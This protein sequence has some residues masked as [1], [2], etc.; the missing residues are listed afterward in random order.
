MRLFRWVPLMKSTF[1][2]ECRPGY[3]GVAVSG[4]A[5]NEQ[6]RPDRYTLTCLRSSPVYQEHCML[7]LILPSTNC[8]F[9]PLSMHNSI[10][11]AR[12]RHGR[13]QLK[14][15]SLKS[16]QYESEI[17]VAVYSKCNLIFFFIR[18]ACHLLIERRWPYDDVS[19]YVQRFHVFT[20]TSED[21]GFTVVQFFIESISFYKWYYF[22][23]HLHLSE[24]LSYKHIV[25]VQRLPPGQRTLSNEINQNPTG[26]ALLWQITVDTPHCCFVE[27]GTINHVHQR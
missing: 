19:R 15:L 27:W 16:I 14:L 2:A 6:R 5:R 7:M 1:C 20:G 22:H 18:P 9:L 13:W 24:C 10:T 23:N 17:T 11:T 8:R 25:I 4:R 26:N 3:Q 21:K 12:M